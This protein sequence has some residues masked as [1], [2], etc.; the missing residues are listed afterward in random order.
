MIDERGLALARRIVEKI[1][2]D[3]TRLG[4]EHARIVCDRWYQNSPTKAYAEWKNILAENWETIKTVL[5]D[6]SERGK[7]L[8]QNSPFCGI[9]TPEERSQIF[10]SYSNE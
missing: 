10:R 8:R 1:D 9:L 2:S 3:P 7:Q 5:L 4:L 6:T